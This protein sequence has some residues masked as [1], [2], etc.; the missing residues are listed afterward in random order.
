MIAFHW[1]MW[2]TVAEVRAMEMQKE[3]SENRCAFETFKSA[4]CHEVKRHGDLNY[5]LNSIQ[6]DIVNYYWNKQWY[7]EAFY[8]L[9]MLDYLCRV[10]GLPVCTDYDNIRNCSLK[11]PVYPRDV[12][13]C[14]SLSTALDSRNECEKQAIPEFKRFNIMECDVRNVY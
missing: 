6:K 8:T 13:F 5:L 14:A 11:E 3:L 9:A 10:N 4:V 1:L 12:D 2:Y 7:F